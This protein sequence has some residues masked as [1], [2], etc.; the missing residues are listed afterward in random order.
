MT[1]LADTAE[2]TLEEDISAALATATAAEV[3]ADDVATSEPKET[4]APPEGPGRDDSG[5]FKAKEPVET[6]PEPEPAAPVIP[7]RFGVAPNYAKKAIRDNWKDLPLDVRTELHDREREFHQQLTRYDEDRN[8]GKKVKEVV[9]PYAPFIKSLGADP[10]QAVDYLIKTDYALRTAAP[11]QRKALFMKA[12]ADY[13]VTFA[14]DELNT[15][16]GHVSDPRVETL[17]QRLE[18]LER[19]QQSVTQERQLAEQHSIE[20]Q[21]ADFS[22]KPENVYFETVSPMMAS[23]L[24]S[25][26]ASSLEQAY[27]MAVYANPETRALQLAAQQGAEQSQRSEQEKAQAA[28]A[29]RASVSVTGAPGLAVPASGQNSAGSLEDDIRNAIQSASS[30]V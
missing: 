30:R 26:Q 3:P 14:G 21:I 8:F 18:R 20:Q 28:A 19:D 23:L 16:S 22:S 7:D 13:G 27:D 12:A 17:Q 24:S 5:K 1:P 6:A 25:G 4:P 2:T 29:R 10:I 11:E 9:D 15:Q